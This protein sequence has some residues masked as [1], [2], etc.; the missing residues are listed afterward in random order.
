MLFQRIGRA[1]RSSS[2]PFR[3]FNC[4]NRPAVHIHIPEVVDLVGIVA[5]EARR[6]RRPAL[7]EGAVW[8]MPVLRAG[9]PA[10][11]GLR[12]RKLLRRT[13]RAAAELHRAGV[14]RVLTA[15]DFPCWPVLEAEG[16][17]AVDCEPFCQALAVP[18]AL[19][20]LRRAGVLRTRATV[21]LT[22]PRVSRPLFAAAEA[23]CPRV[24]HLIVDVPGEGEELAAWLREEYG[25]AV[26]S[27]DA[28]ADVTLCFGPGGRAR[29]GAVLH[30]Y[31]PDPELAGLRPAP[32]EGALPETLAPLP[33]LAL[34]WENG[35]LTAEQIQIFPT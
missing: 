27:P 14:R 24:R 15:A 25:A 3:L 20:G 4:I 31:G 7:E 8:G 12:E 34:L 28:G 17:R 32:A 16:L 35:R 10:P 33:L 6:G 11:P 21:A 18:L 26:L 22:S 30:L 13:A 2:R 19:A 1:G 23:L 29:C 9:V 5:L